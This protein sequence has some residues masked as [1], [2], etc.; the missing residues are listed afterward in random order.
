[1]PQ[2]KLLDQETE[3][4]SDSNNVSGLNFDDP[5]RLVVFRWLNDSKDFINDTTN[6]VNGKTVIAIISI[7]VTLCKDLVWHSDKHF[8]K[9]SVSLVQPSSEI[10]NN[11]IRDQPSYSLRDDLKVIDKFMSQFNIF[12]KFNDDATVLMD[13]I[14]LNQSKRQSFDA[15]FDLLLYNKSLMISRACIKF[16]SDEIILGSKIFHQPILNLVYNIV[17]KEIDNEIYTFLTEL[18]NE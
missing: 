4:L 6:N 2:L 5:P 11:I 15:Y 13:S 14:L 3:Y 12:Y 16:S 9:V 10:Y 1:M 17:K 8:L 7:Y 18:N